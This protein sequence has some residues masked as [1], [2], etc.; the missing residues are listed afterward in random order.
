[1]A[2]AFEQLEGN[3][4]PGVELLLDLVAPGGPAVGEG[5]DGVDVAGVVGQEDLAGP[6]VVLDEAHLGFLPVLIV[7]GAG[8]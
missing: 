8:I 3:V 4:L 6:A 7:P 2:R 1:M 5:F